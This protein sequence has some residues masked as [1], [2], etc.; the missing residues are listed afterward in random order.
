MYRMRK[1]VAIF[2]W[3]QAGK[4]ACQADRMACKP[5]CRAWAADP[6]KTHAPARYKPFGAGASHFGK[7]KM[8]LSLWEGLAAQTAAMFQRNFSGELLLQSG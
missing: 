5:F 2:G 7:P 6:T 3:C 4:M 8:S 1:P